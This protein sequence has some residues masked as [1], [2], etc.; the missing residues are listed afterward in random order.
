MGE[1]ENIKKLFQEEI[2]KVDSLTSLNEVRNNY[3]GKSGHLTT[4]MK[5]IKD[6]QAEEK[7]SFGENVNKLIN[8][9]LDEIES[10]KTDLENAKILAELDNMP[11]VDLTTPR[12][13]VTCPGSQKAAKP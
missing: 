12:G 10:K 3:L 9:V 6:L 7:K 4:V 5:V 2:E 11:E 8:Y 1:L 13:N